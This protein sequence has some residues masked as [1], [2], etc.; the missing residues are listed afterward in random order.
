[1]TVTIK[2]LSLQDKWDLLTKYTKR[3]EWTPQTTPGASKSN[4]RICESR[5][6][7]ISCLDFRI[8]NSKI[9]LTEKV[10]ETLPNETEELQPIMLFLH[11]DDMRE[12]RSDAVPGLSP[13]WD[14]IIHV[15]QSRDVPLDPRDVRAK[16]QLDRLLL[17]KQKLVACHRK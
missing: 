11:L 16:C 5:A 9:V 15:T 10:K 7:I 8:E 12:L 6:P 1:L 13:C 2:H 14:H 4:V 3:F 17:M